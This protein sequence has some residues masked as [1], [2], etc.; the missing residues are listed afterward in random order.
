MYKSTEKNDLLVTSIILP[1]GMY[2]ALFKGDC[3]DNLI[4]IF[5]NDIVVSEKKLIQ[6]FFFRISLFIKYRQNAWWYR[7]PVLYLFL[8]LNCNTCSCTNFKSFVENVG[9]LGKFTCV[10]FQATSI[11]VDKLQNHRT[12]VWHQTLLR[13]V[14][15]NLVHIGF[16]FSKYIF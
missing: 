3:Q 14:H 15:P 10:L 6:T 5:L 2:N 13:M 11:M 8:L 1:I 7:Q 4:K 9:L 12:Q 16:L